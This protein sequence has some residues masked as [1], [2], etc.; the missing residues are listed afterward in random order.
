M[1]VMRHALNI[2][3]D[4]TFHMSAANLLFPKRA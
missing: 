4:E 3:L 2:V 1:T